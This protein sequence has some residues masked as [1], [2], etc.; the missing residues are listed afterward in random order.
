MTSVFCFKIL[1]KP[2]FESFIL[3]LDYMNL[4]NPP[5]KNMVP[6]PITND[7]PKIP[8]KEVLQRVR[9]YFT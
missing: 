5:L 6:L 9:T 4:L 8:D 2:C 7:L 1:M 3:N